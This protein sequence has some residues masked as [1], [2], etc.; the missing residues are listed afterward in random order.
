MSENIKSVITCDLDGK[1]ETF[2]EGAVKLFGY[3]EEEVIGKMRVSD[4]SDGQ[5]VLGH[6]IGWLDE[7]VKNGKWEAREYRPEKKHPNHKNIVDTVQEYHNNPWTIKELKKY[8]SPVYYQHFD[9]NPNLKV[10][11]QQK[12]NWFM[13]LNNY[14]SFAN[15]SN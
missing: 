13:K 7:S 10:F 4:F 11:T 1:V 6:V 8:Q 14:C 15:S 3:S 2:S 12:N 9:A 5:V